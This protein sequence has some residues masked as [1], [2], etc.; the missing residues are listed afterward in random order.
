MWPY[1]AHER[2]SAS[3]E[4]PHSE[5]VTGRGSLTCDGFN[6]PQPGQGCVVSP[7]VFSIVARRNRPVDALLL[8]R[9]MVF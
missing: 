3:N 2:Q 1:P 9:D 4:P 5:H 6:D 7:N 8:I